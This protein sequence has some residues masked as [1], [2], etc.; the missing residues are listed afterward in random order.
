MPAVQLNDHVYWV[1][2]VDADVREFHGYQVPYGTTYN[3]YLVLGEKIALIDSVKAPFTKVMME[4]IAQVIDPAKI[5]YIVSNHVEPDHS[6]ALAAAV[7][8]A[9]NAPVITT[10]NGKKG[11]SVYYSPDWNYQVVKTGDTLSLGNYTLQFVA[12]PMVHWPDNMVTYLQED[13][14]LFS[15]DAFGQ[16]QATV[17]R[18]ADE[19]GAKTSLER[20]RD[21]YANIVMPFGT[22]VNAALKA[23]GGL[24]L[25]TIAPSHGVIW[26]TPDVIS[27]LLAKYADWANNRVRDD[28]AVIVFDTMWG[29]TEMLAHR[30]KDEFEAQGVEV[31]LI[32][33]REN[34]ISRAMDA[35]LEAKYICVGSP[36]LNRS[37]MPSVA[38]FLCYLKGLAPKGR[39]GQAFG[40]HGWSG[41]A[42]GYIEQMLTE[43]KFELREKLVCVYRP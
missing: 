3:A 38:A 30:L 31:R 26:R 17:S 42:T 18:F 8:A 32:D 28:L 19:V 21:Y 1:G 2:A 24:T 22:Q 15:N 9:P 43:A 6:G 7:A 27:A 14:I 10:A 35:L 33:L 12:T 29:S 25:N 20:A 11:L 4:N 36:T 23:L 41:E 40:S 39:I 13:G 34:H 37:V 16:H 5:D